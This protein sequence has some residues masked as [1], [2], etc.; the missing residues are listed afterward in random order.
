MIIN[1]KSDNIFMDLINEIELDI[2]LMTSTQI[3][4]FSVIF[5]GCQSFNAPSK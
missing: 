5:L 2:C 3:T 4:I 1:W